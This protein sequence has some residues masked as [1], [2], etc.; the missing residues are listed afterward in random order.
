MSCRRSND[1]NLKLQYKRY[2]KILTGVIK[3]A[4][5][6]YYDEFISKSKNKTK[7]I[8]EIIKK[9]IGKNNCHNVIK[10]LKINYTIPNDPQEIATYFH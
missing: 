9:E 7:T 5:E 6:M 4:K 1:I 10:P 2:C 8:W 3:T